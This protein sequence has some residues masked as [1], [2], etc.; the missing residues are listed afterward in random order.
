MA[1]RSSRFPNSKPKWM[2][3]HPNGK[4]MSIQSVA[5]LDKSHIEKIVFVYLKEHEEKFHFK[6]GFIEELDNFWMKDYS[7]CELPQQT[8]DC[9]ETVVEA[10]KRENLKGPIFI[11]DSDSFFVCKN[12]PVGNFVCHANI[13]KVG[14]VNPC[15]KSY[16]AI[17]ENNIIT[18]VVEKKIISDTFC[19]GGYMFDDADTFLSLSEDLSFDRER[20][21][22]DVIYHA[23]LN[24]QLVFKGI[25]VSGFEDWGTSDD[26]YKYKK[27][28]TTLFVD[29]DGTIVEN[30]SSHFPPYIGESKA[31]IKNVNC[32]KKLLDSKRVEIIFTTSRSEFERIATVVEL[33]RLGL[34]YKELIMGLQHCKRIIINDYSSTNPYKSCDAINL[35]RNSDD[36][37][38]LLEG[39]LE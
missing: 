12:L 6:K 29:I 30:S 37:T 24:K 25:E 27:T 10:I 18:N 11:K 9:V 13:G 38:E 23:I 28:F 17:D 4:F 1:G 35:K 34:K 14:R 5:E 16:I 26:W 33:E 20:Y 31:I 39:I 7:L 36:L 19:V 32:L 8:K 22:S 3:T 15:A 21:V 2:L